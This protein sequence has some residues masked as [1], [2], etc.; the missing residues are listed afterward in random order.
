MVHV[1]GD[2]DI[3]K[4]IRIHIARNSILFEFSNFANK[5]KST[6]VVVDEGNDMF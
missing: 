5:S 2:C 6:L 4:K 1:A 3:D